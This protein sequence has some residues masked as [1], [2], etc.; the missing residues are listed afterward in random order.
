MI[1][2]YSLVPE[3]AKWSNRVQD[4]VL[5]V[6]ELFYRSFTEEYPEVTQHTDKLPKKLYFGTLPELQKLERVEQP[7]D[8]LPIYSTMFR[9]GVPASQLDPYYFATSP[10]RP[11]YTDLARGQIYMPSQFINSLGVHVRAFDQERQARLIKLFGAH[12]VGEA[13]TILSYRVDPDEFREWSLFWR[14]QMCQT[15][16]WFYSETEPK[17]KHLNNKK[18]RMRFRQTKQ[19]ALQFLTEEEVRQDQAHYVATGAQVFMYHYP[20]TS[21][22]GAE[23]SLGE[24]F[25]ESTITILSR[26]VNSRFEGYID[27]WLDRKPDTPKETPPNDLEKRAKTIHEILGLEGQ[28]LFWA[29]IYSRIP[30]LYMECD[31]PRLDPF[32]YAKLAN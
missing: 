28:E 21:V 25:N 24:P 29:F 19:N 7:R 26:P 16:D 2:A 4:N 1:E 23:L 27:E 5:K 22:A 12:M 13:L 6:G 18:D 3:E 8:K 14:M 10:K 32:A 9:A 17:L 11:Y 20:A 30:R 15:I 31:D